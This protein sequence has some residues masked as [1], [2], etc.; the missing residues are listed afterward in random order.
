MTRESLNKAG[1]HRL[2]SLCVFFFFALGEIFSFFFPSG[3][4]FYPAGAS[5]FFSVSHTPASEMGTRNSASHLR[6]CRTNLDG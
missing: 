6:V 1:P 3:A 4:N 5:H 2:V